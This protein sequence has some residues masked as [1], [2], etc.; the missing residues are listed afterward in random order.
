M[1]N[2]SNASAPLSNT[3]FSSYLGETAENRFHTHHAIWGID[4]ALRMGD[5]L[6]P[7]EDVPRFEASGIASNNEEAMINPRQY[8]GRPF[9]IMF[10]SGAFTASGENASTL[11]TDLSISKE[12]KLD[13][14]II[15]T[16]SMEVLQA[17]ANMNEHGSLPGNAKMISDK[18]G[19]IARA[20]GVLD[21]ETHTAYNSVFLIDKQG[22]VQAARVSAFPE[23]P[24]IGSGT[25]VGDVIELIGDAL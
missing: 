14:L 15:S 7:G 21:I 3:S 24:S 20:F 8:L 1:S 6:L 10:H 18:T 2:K 22:V 25:G 9:I 11:I 13:Y 23:V 5:P 16:D 12:V 19:D 17:W 4:Y